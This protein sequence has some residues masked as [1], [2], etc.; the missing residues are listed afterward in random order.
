MLPTFIKK[1]IA[2]G[3]RTIEVWALM[4][5]LP[6]VLT[7]I[8]ANAFSLQFEN[9]IEL[10]PIEYGL[11]QND[12]SYTTYLMDAV[13]DL[14]YITLTPLE[15]AEAR[16]RSENGEY[17]GYVVLNESGIEFHDNSLGGAVTSV[18]KGFLQIFVDRYQLY[19]VGL[20]P[21][22]TNAVNVRGLET[23]DTGGPYDYFGVTVLTLILAYVGQMTYSSFDDERKGF[24]LA[25]IKA[26][27][28]KPLTIFLGKM[29]GVL[30]ITMLQIFIIMAFNILVYKVNYGN[31]P[32]TFITML[33]LSFMFQCFGAFIAVYV[34]NSSLANGILMF[35]TQA[36][37]L[38]GGGYFQITDSMSFFSRMQKI[39]PVG[40]VNTAMRHGI[41]GGETSRFYS[42]MLIT[43]G[44]GFVLLL[45]SAIR[46]NDMEAK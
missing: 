43:V 38:F 16:N 8:L 28:A 30:F 3:L 42:A 32:L 34:S 9:D 2:Q 39:S 21:V 13:E 5:L 17:G 44:I 6:I 11:V 37:I 36:A 31:I 46:F 4:I 22:E 20:T 18:L 24:T 40:I 15:E 14:D 41:Y 29:S 27:P 45:I 26:S 25:R 12:E 33:C 7:L 1:E 10:D 19:S 23:K 35:V